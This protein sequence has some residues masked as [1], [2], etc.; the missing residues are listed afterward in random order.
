[1]R[2]AALLTRA[3]EGRVPGGMS[4]AAVGTALSAQGHASLHDIMDPRGAL[5]PAT[6]PGAASRQEGPVQAAAERARR[7]RIARVFLRLVRVAR[8]ET[9]YVNGPGSQA[10]NRLAA[11]VQY[12]IRAR[13]RGVDPDQL[14]AIETALVLELMRVLRA[15]FGS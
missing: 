12:W 14:A 2:R 8:T 6:P 11:A 7:R 9:V 10:L 4:S 1:M 15:T 5:A 13:I 3:V